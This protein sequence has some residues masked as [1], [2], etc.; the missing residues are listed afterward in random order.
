MSVIMS[1]K[2]RC[3]FHG[4]TDPQKHKEKMRREPHLNV[5]LGQYLS[6]DRCICA[7]VKDLQEHGKRCSKKK[8]DRRRQFPRPVI[9]IGWA[10]VPSQAQLEDEPTRAYRET[11]RE[12]ERGEDNGMKVIFIGWTQ[13]HHGQSQRRR[14]HA[15]KHE[16][17]E[18]GRG[19]R[20]GVR[21]ISAWPEN[22]SCPC[23]CL[24]SVSSSLTLKY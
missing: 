13:I 6:L 3:D 22:S 23:I 21:N 4:P 10:Q 15:H 8:K 7:Q 19:G 24:G 1:H 14:T 2:L 18:E 11:D 17:G 20:A 9:S 12:R 5:S 16:H